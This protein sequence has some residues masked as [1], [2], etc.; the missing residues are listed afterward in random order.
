MARWRDLTGDAVEYAPG[1]E[2]ADRFPQVS[3]RQLDEAV[4]LIMPDGAVHAGADAVCAVLRFAPGHAWKAWAYHRVPGAGR[5]ADGLYAFT[6]AHRRHLSRLTTLGWGRDPSPSTYAVAGRLYL[7]LLGLV[8][9]IAIVSLASQIQ[10]LVGSHGILPVGQYLE[11]AGEQLGP[12]RYL[13]LPTLCWIDSGDGFLYGLCTAGVLLA[14]LLTAGIAPIPVLAMLWLVYLSLSVAGQAFCSF[15]W[16]TLLLEAGFLAMFLAPRPPWAWRPPPQRPPASGLW[17]QRLLLFKLM[18][19]SGITKLLSGDPAWRDL[20]ALPVHYQT[21]PLP[22]WIGYFAYGLPEWFH[23][24]SVVA[25]YV[26]EIGFALLIFGPRRVRHVAG[27]GLILFQVL[28][29]ATGNYGFFNLLAVVLC[30]PLFDDRLLK[31]LAPR[32]LGAFFQAPPRRHAAGLG[33]AAVLTATAVITVLSGLA[34]LREMVRTQRRNTTPAPVVFVLDALDRCLLSWGEPVLGVID[35]LRTINGYGLFRVMTTQRPEIVIEG[36][37][38][39]RTW[40]EY[41][42]AWKPGALDHRPGLVAPHQPRLDWQM[43]FAALNPTGN[44]YWLEGLLER[45]LEGE[46]RV[47]ALLKGDSFAGKPPRSVRLVY[48]RYRFTDR[49]TRKR[50]G[51]WWERE[52]LGELT[53]PIS[54]GAKRAGPTS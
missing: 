51:R 52:R 38:D 3:R 27:A 25:M 15:Q 14:V 33:R 29:A 47:T 4:V 17:L 53:A 13:Q 26:I 54:L 43:W 34:L 44:A 35:P 24:A 41:E 50:T 18:F 1:G 46:P 37:D 11:R 22:T 6:A 39:G 7:S 5:A 36:S 21:Q 19:L 28:I 40:R 42:F 20:S 32:R 10:G 45:L 30:V 12:G 31:R 9:L 8:F 48:Y 16:D 49:D 2:V 23:H